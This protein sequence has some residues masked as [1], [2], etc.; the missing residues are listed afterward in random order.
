MSTNL[1]EE[2]PPILGDRGQMQQVFLNLIMKAVESMSSVTDRSRELGI[3]S[4]IVQGSSNIVLAVE[5]S[6]IGIETKH[7]D[8]VFEPFFTTKATGTGIG[9]TICRSIIESHG[10]S[11]RAYAKKPHGTVFEVVIPSYT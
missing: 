2:V 10:G 7:Q 9:L 6:G 4:G 8:C 1:N 3:L 11:M 5:D